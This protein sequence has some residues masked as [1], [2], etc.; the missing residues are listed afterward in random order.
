MNVYVFQLD[1]THILTWRT[2]VTPVWTFYNAPDSM[3]SL[4]SSAN[5]ILGA[6]DHEAIKFGANIAIKYIFQP[7][8][9][10]YCKVG[11]PHSCLFTFKSRLQSAFVSLDIANSRTD[12]VKSGKSEH[13]SKNDF[14]KEFFYPF[15]ATVT[16]WIFS[17]HSI[18]PFSRNMNAGLNVANN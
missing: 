7:K 16:Q 9:F 4:Y 18:E 1:V 13:L 3:M 15:H 11:A 8:W 10:T 2:T 12:G 17:P 14:C 5:I 6:E